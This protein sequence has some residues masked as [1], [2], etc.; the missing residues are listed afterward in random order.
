MRHDLIRDAGNMLKRA[1]EQ[2]AAGNDAEAIR[3]LREATASISRFNVH[4]G[5]DRIPT[6]IRNDLNRALKEQRG[7]T[8]TI[9]KVA[10]AALL[11]AAS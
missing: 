10:I 5:K 3:L 8:V 11:E 4:V 9:T 6:S 7:S 2:F 1:S